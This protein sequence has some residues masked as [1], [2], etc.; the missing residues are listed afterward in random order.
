MS[1]FTIITN[2]GLSKIAAAAGGGANLSLTH[3]AVGDGNG[4]DVTPVATAA[5]LVNERYR[6]TANRVYTETGNPN[7]VICELVLPADQ[8]GWTIKEV[9]V[10]DVAGDLIVF[11]NFPSTYKPLNTEGAVRESVIRIALIHSN[12]DVVT[13]QIDPSIVTSTQQYV[14]DQLEDH[15][16]KSDPHTQYLK[17]ADAVPVGT[18]LDYAGTLQPN[19][20]LC[21]W[22]ALSP[23]V[24]ATLFSKIGYTW[25]RSGDLFHVPPSD[26]YARGSGIYAVG[27][28]QSDQNKSHQHYVANTSTT[29]E[30]ISSSNSLAKNGSWGDSYINYSL[31]GTTTT[32]DAGLTSSSGS[33]E[34]RPPTMVVTKMIKY[35]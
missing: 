5:S 1:Y 23:T 16:A 35:Q 9:G 32:P 28:L 4:S 33:T 11:T 13:L 21:N 14:I 8:G 26:R 10:F 2:T 25:G 12:A 15:E 3:M 27:T 20:L 22:G 17:K 31:A 34:G 7:K 29:S 24:Y 6:S 18:I 19:Y 30:S